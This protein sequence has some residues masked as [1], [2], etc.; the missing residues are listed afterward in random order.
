VGLTI[1]TVVGLEAPEAPV[2]GALLAMV[3]D[4]LLALR[5][6]IEA[7]AAEP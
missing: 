5:M 7:T 2:A 6:P 3:M 4:K 1:G